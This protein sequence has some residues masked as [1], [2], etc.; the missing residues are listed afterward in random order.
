MKKV[1]V[2]NS[3]P[4]AG[5]F[6]DALAESYAKGARYSGAEV[7]ELALRNL[8]FDLNFPGYG[9]E[10]E[11]VQGDI[12]RVQK[13]LMWGSHIVI[14]HPVW[15]GT[16]PALLKGFLDRT[17]LPGFAF[18]SKGGNSYE[19][20]L[21]GRTARIISTMDSPPWYYRLKGRPGQR[22]LRDHV[23]KFVG[24]DPVRLSSY[25]PI[26]ESTVGKRMA[27]LA[28]AQAMGERIV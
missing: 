3:H 21:T 12:A 27:W 1:L 11:T 10:P 20:L 24:M 14:I 15:W 4:G 5:S 7:E 28:A 18:R 2:I 16:Y 13:L 26:K 22:A 8:R 17:L 23:L 9:R 6:C 25:G 19:R